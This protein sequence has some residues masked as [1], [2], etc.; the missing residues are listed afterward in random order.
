MRGFALSAEE[1]REKSSFERYMQLHKE[2]ALDLMQMYQGVSVA[3]GIPEDVD[4]LDIGCGSGFFMHSMDYIQKARGSKESWYGV[5]VEGSKS[6]I[7]NNT[8]I[9][10]D[11]LPTFR[12][13][14]AG[15]A[16]PIF[17]D[18]NAKFMDK[19]RG[20]DQLKFDVA[21]MFY[22]LHHIAEDQLDDVI[23]QTY[24]QLKP[25]G[26]LVILEDHVGMD[27]VEPKRMKF[28][29]AMDNFFY[30]DFP[31]NQKP[32]TEWVERLVKAGFK[33]RQL[34]EASYYNSIGI[35]TDDALIVM[36]KPLA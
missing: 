1:Y 7:T 29:K 27:A 12:E 9:D 18:P 23:K 2:R 22:V 3:L 20:R 8:R 6:P 32:V 24:D 19:V 13:F 34:G 31:G 25:G 16:L 35:R 10:R 28:I 17:R 21:T 14:K 30:P 11:R 4:G 33:E 26:K 5:D 36:E 15:K